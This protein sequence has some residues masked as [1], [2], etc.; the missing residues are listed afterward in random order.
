[1]KIFSG[2]NFD[3]DALESYFGKRTKKQGFL[4]R[5]PLETVEVSSRL[6]RPFRFIHWLDS[7]YKELGV[8]LLDESIDGSLLDQDEQLLLWRPRYVDLKVED[9]KTIEQPESAAEPK[10]DM[11]KRIADGLIK[12]RQDAQSALLES[13]PDALGVDM[14][15]AFSFI[16]PKL[17]KSQ[18]QRSRLQDEVRSL[19]AVIRGTSMVAKVPQEALIHSSGIGERVFVGTY[20]VKYRN[21][22]T[23]EMRFEFMETP[24]ADSLKDS[25]SR[26]L[27][28]T[29]LCE[30]SKRSRLFAESLMS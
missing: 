8:T 24:G 23:D 13:N 9:S 2:P 11:A 6:W 30:L 27:P 19:V 1:M 4:G 3:T 17:P 16:I 20:V 7:D 14:Q 26:G 21:L 5:E 22:S 15:A 29:R 18:R 28:F 12:R 25:L 10:E